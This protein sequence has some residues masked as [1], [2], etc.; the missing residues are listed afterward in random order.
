MNLKE[1]THINK[2]YKSLEREMIDFIE[3]G[4]ADYTLSDVRK[5]LSLL[6]NF[7][8]EISKTD[9]RETGIL[10]VKKTVLAINNLNENCE[11]ELVETEQREK[12]A[13]I[14]ILAGHL[15]GY[16]HINEDTT[17]EWREW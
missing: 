5:C 14:I 10:T 13:D 2:T 6:D 11:Y 3:L 17:E 1:N 16:N 12:I 15:K 9:S 8:D 4:E 7:L